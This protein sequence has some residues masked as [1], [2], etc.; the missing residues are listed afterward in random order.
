MRDLVTYALL[1][2]LSVAGGLVIRLGVRWLDAL[3]GHSAR[4]RAGKV[5]MPRATA[6]TRGR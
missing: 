3:H 1:G 6:R 4:P 2:A 5:E